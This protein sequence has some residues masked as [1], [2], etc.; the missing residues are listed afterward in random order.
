MSFAL[1]RRAAIKGAVAA[2]A[3]AAAPTAVFAASEAAHAT[4]PGQTG[5]ITFRRGNEVWIA[6]ADGTNQRRL[7]TNASAGSGDWSPDGSRFL[8]HDGARPVSIRPDGS[9]RIDFLD[10]NRVS[11]SLNPVYAYGGRYVV[12]NS[13][14]KLSIT[15]SGANWPIG[16]ELFSAP[17]DGLFDSNVTTWGN[18]VVY[19]HS[20]YGQRQGAVINR[21][22]GEYNPFTIVEDGWAPDFAP[23]GNRIAFVRTAGDASQIWIADSDGSNEWQLTTVENSGSTYNYDPAWAPDSSAILFSTYAS[24]WTP[25]VRRIDL[26]TKEIV[27]LVENGSEPTCQPVNGQYVHRVWGQDALLTAVAT[28]RWNWTDKGVVDGVR[29]SAKAVVLSRDD[30]YFDALGG[31]ALAVVKEGPLLI[32]PPGSLATATEAEIKRVLGTTGTVYLLGGTVALSANVENKLKSLGYT[33]VRLWGATEY[34]TAIAVA[35]A[36][37]TKPAAVILATSL[38]Y[39]DA[40]AAGAAAG[41]SPGTVIVLTNGDNMP[42]ATAAYLNRLDP[43]VVDMIGVGGPGVRALENGYDRGQLPSWENISE[44][45]YYYPV[46]GATEFETAVAVAEFFFSGPRYAAVA[47]ATTWYDALTGGSMI[48]A[49]GGPLLLSAPG[50]LSPQTRAY[51]S[52]NS[53]SIKYGVLLGGYLALSDNLIEPLG[54]AI[55]LPGTHKYEQYTETYTVPTTKPKSLA[56][57]ADVKPRGTTTATKGRIPG[58]TANKGKRITG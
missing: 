52:D 13:Y 53:A 9:D 33:T 17:D 7:V 14:S 6:N 2:T 26:D 58:T 20:A 54:K 5:Q 48:G 34:D 51:L 10:L 25:R 12:F 28:S 1:S 44:V 4:Q 43:R 29:S 45:W 56:K 27:T 3:V 30:K 40:L 36:I 23:D 11:S 35:N 47:T 38:K 39:Y 21:L 42:A 41:A 8:F 32:T 46:F 16:L 55:S 50:S 18:E 19:Q 24:G 49:N 31:S 15:S 57:S 22:D 37:T